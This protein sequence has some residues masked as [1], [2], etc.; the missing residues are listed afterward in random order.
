MVK[1]A[2]RVLLEGIF[3]GYRK[4]S[5]IKKRGKGEATLVGGSHIDNRN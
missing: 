2:A 5:I 1:Q 4:K 3:K